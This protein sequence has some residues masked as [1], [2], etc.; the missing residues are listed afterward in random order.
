MSTKHIKKPILAYPEQSIKNN[1]NRNI[2]LA[3]K[4]HVL[5]HSVNTYILFY[6]VL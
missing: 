2:Q 5:Y 6:D 3:A 4:L 1:D